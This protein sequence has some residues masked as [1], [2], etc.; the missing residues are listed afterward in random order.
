[1]KRLILTILLIISLLVKGYSQQIARANIPSAFKINLLHSH[2][3][4]PAEDLYNDI[5]DHNSLNCYNNKLHIQES[6]NINLTPFNMPLN[7]QNI[8]I[9]SN[10]GY[11]P[12]FRRQHKG[13]DLGLNVGD[14]IYSTFSGKVRI[15]KHDAKG[16][17]NYV[18]IRHFN[19]LET[20]YAHMS[21]RLVKN[22]EYIYCGQP[23]GLGG[24][25][26][27]STGPHLHL[28]VRF[29]GIPIDPRKIFNFAHQDV[30]EDV[31]VFKQ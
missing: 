5:W 9:N 13:I 16:F 8:K 31:F 30:V 11:R 4:N 21:K 23:I 24:N 3:V 27:R 15:S 18:V 25:T 29:C 20:V 10:F 14:T 1:M 22:D 2:L 12:K 26:G 7:K 19:G 17:G 28:E 6:H